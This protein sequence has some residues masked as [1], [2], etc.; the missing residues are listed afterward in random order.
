[1]LCELCNKS[2]AVV[3]L[4][5]VSNN[6]RAEK[7]LCKDCAASQ[8]ATIKS[9]MQK[10]S[11]STKDAGDVLPEIFQNLSATSGAAGAETCGQCG[12]TYRQFRSSG[13]FGCPECYV[14]FDVK[15]S[16]L[17]EKIHGRCEHTGKVP[18]TASD[19]LAQQKELQTQQKRLQGLYADLDKAV[20]DEDYE[21]AAELRDEIQRMQE[22]AA[23]A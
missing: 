13:K 5:D 4:V 20:N 23:E 8:G 17:L 22:G 10:S 1:M 9:H 7:H 19:D 12:T 2:E 16:D 18:S 11:S 21:R 3:H 14:E 15:V 6:S